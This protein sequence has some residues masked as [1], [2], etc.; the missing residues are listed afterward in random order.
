MTKPTLESWLRLRAIDGVGDQTIFRLVRA[1]GSPD[2]VL[3]A[4]RDELIQSGCSPLLANAIRRGL[5]HST[6]RSIDRE[7]KAIERE[8]VEVRSLLDSQYPARLKMIADPPP[9]LYITGTLTE[10]DELAVAIVGARRATA[11]GRA[12]TEELGHDLA[13]AGITVVS[14]LARGIDA[15]AHRGALAVEGR[16]I[17]VLGCGIDRTYPPEHERLRRQI[18]ERGAIVSEVAMGVPPHSHHFPRRNRII[19][20]LSLG[21]IVTEAAVG[22]GSLI[23]AR[24]AAEQGRE[25]FAV[26]G[27]VKHDTSRGTNALLKEGAALIERAQDVIDA[28][29]PQLEPT[30]RVRVRPSREKKASGDYLGKEEQLVY[31]VLSY[32]PSTVDDVIVSTRLPVS[33]VMASLLSLELQQRVMQLPGQRYLRT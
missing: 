25:V 8:R 23:T 6:N 15:A 29:L 27:F 3:R 18:E 32:D 21:V 5:D 26:P 13:A 2:A 31:D 24:L 4:S 7:I 1:W 17:A 30:L 33:T 14:G 16:T 10:Q 19:S 28:L 9:L 12:I 20:G 22:S 11:A